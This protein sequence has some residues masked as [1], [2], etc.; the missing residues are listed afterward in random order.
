[1]ELR[2]QNIAYL[3]SAKIVENF[4][5]EDKSVEEGCDSV[6]KCVDTLREFYP[7]AKL[8]V[9]AI[10]PRLDDDQPRARQINNLVR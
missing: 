1:M 4:V 2:L 3:W 7:A 8:W 6:L 5:R 9:S 10:L